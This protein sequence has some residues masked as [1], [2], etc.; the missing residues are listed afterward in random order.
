MNVLKTQMLSPN[1]D[2]SMLPAVVQHAHTLQIIMSGFVDRKSYNVGSLS[3]PL[4]LFTRYGENDLKII[5]EST[6]RPLKIVD[7]YRDSFNETLLILV[8]PKGLSVDTTFGQPKAHGVGVISHL[9]SVIEER[10]MFGDHYS[11]TNKLFRQGSAKIAQK[12]SADV[13]DM[14]VKVLN[15]NNNPTETVQEAADIIYHL[16]MLL[17]DQQINI[18][19]IYEE[20][21]SRINK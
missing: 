9:W 20:I 7:I 19:Q 18:E 14:M 17:Q 4:T 2:Q 3:G 1:Q 12:L 6:Q 16:F 8:V 13:S 10:H 11:Y 21:R 5:E 15:P